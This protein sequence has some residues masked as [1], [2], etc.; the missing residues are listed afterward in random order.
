MRLENL[1][2]P[3][4][5]P[6]RV[7]PGIHTAPPTEVPQPW[8]SCLGSKQKGFPTASSLPGSGNLTLPTVRPRLC[9]LNILNLQLWSKEASVPRLTE[10]RAPNVPPMLKEASIQDNKLYQPSD[11]NQNISP[12]ARWADRQVCQTRFI[13]QTGS[14]ALRCACRPYPP[15]ESAWAAPGDRFQW[16]FLCFRWLLFCAAVFSPVGGTLFKRGASS[17]SRLLFHDWFLLPPQT[18]LNAWSPKTP[19]T[20]WSPRKALLSVPHS[21]AIHFLPDYLMNKRVFFPPNYIKIR[22]RKIKYIQKD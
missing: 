17:L 19:I 15:A 4:S 3:A 6:L 9:S 16:D 2:L 13:S 1:Q 8:P 22:K 11:K 21:P 7:R 14:L 20:F 10:E 5:P 12:L 18:P